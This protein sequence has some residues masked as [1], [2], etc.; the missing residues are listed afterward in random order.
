MIN[1]KTQ[2]EALQVTAIGSTE[3]TLQHFTYTYMNI[4]I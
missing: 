3:K 4:Y 1:F 2:N